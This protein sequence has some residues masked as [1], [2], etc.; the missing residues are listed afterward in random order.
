M[1]NN[2][3]QI[4]VN[5]NFNLKK[6]I[7]YSIFCK[8][9]DNLGEDVELS[10]KYYIIDN[11]IS[12]FKLEEDSF[13]QFSRLYDVVRSIRLSINSEFIKD[14]Y[15]KYPIIIPMLEKIGSSCSNFI[16]NNDVNSITNNYL[17]KCL[18]I[19]H[20]K[21][22]ND[23]ESNLSF[24]TDYELILLYKNENN[25]KARNEIIMR[26]RGLISSVCNKFCK[27]E[28]NYDDLFQSGVEGFIYGLDK[29]DFSK[30]TKFS[31]YIVHWI[32]HYVRFECYELNNLISISDYYKN[33][34]SIFIKA[35]NSLKLEK[36]EVSIKDLVDRT[37]L[38]ISLVQLYIKYKDGPIYL[39]DDNDTNDYN[40]IDKVSYSTCNNLE[41]LIIDRIVNEELLDIVNDS[42]MTDKEK[43]VFLSYFGIN[44]N[45][46][47][48]MEIK[49]DLMCSH[50]NVSQLKLK[51]LKK[52]KK[53]FR[54]YKND[55]LD[56]KYGNWAKIKL[57]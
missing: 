28:S 19:F 36:E 41:D 6:F 16:E 44:C 24:Y 57:K 45:S 26:N 42:D 29:F 51:S 33:K 55:S 43:Y 13:K 54:R 11:I 46:K 10:L 18:L 22:N 14:I 8:I 1:E 5:L 20:Y 3:E 49:D 35:Y 53:F 2:I 7:S 30:E 48:L 56:C 50:Q 31:T 23:L 34:Y 21:L 25:K 38:P 40:M 17:L 15:N 52:F 27:N 12:S 47:T 37:N 4:Y 32:E 9:Y 39:D